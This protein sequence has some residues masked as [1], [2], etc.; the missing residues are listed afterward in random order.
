MTIIGMMLDIIIM[1]LLGV[2]IF[3]AL[4]L[5]KSLS[6]IRDS[7]GDMARMMKDLTRNIEK[8]EDAV[9]RLKNTANDSGKDLQV[10]INESK[11]L[12]EELQ[13]INEASDSLARRLEQAVEKS[14]NRAA[15]QENYEDDA[16]EQ[17]FSDPELEK[18]FRPAQE[19][20]HRKPSK[21]SYK[22]K[23]EEPFRKSRGAYEGGF[24]IRDPDFDAGFEDHDDQENSA[25]AGDMETD[26]PRTEAERD[27]LAAIQKKRKG[28][29]S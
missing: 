3:Y 23:Q 7:R 13:F 2:T 9:L 11:A 26:I 14:H 6:V 27:L 19:T 28:G 16:V 25:G 5:S 29:S 20:P 10:I 22:K 12:S 15:V 4:R 18:I 21:P 17:Y 8:A 24:A 1:L